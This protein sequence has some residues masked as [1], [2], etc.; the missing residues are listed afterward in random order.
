MDT[1]KATLFRIDSGK[2]KEKSTF[3]A[4]DETNAVM[5]ARSLY[6]EAKLSGKYL[7]ETSTGRIHSIEIS[8]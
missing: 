5:I 6:R 2:R 8:Y 3:M 7:L 1:I 4:K